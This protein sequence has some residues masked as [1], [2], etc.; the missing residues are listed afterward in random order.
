MQWNAE[1]VNAFVASRNLARNAL[2]QF[3]I[4]RE[5]GMYRYNE[6]SSQALDAYKDGFF[7]GDSI[8][9]FKKMDAIHVKK[10]DAIHDK[11]AQKDDCIP[12]PKESKTEEKVKRTKYNKP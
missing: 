4:D 11:K 9:T 2:N 1:N 5:S 8:V 7:Q 10:M 6:N 3:E 12:K